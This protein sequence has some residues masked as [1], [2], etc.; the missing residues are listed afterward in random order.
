[1]N[2]GKS[3]LCES[4]WTYHERVVDMISN[5]ERSPRKVKAQ[6]PPWKAI[7]WVIE[8]DFLC[9]V[10]DTANKEFSGNIRKSYNRI[11]LVV[12]AQIKAGID[13]VW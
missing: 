1:M 11:A 9:L 5:P 6:K 7:G 2:S 4:R 10:V 13:A 12:A 3:R 8:L